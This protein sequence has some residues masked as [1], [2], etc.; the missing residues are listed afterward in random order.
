MG[1]ASAFAQPQKLIN[2]ANS[3]AHEANAILKAW[4]LDD[5]NIRGIKE[6]D[7]LTGETVASLQFKT[8]IPDEAERKIND[9]LLNTKDAFDRT[10]NAACGLIGAT[11][12]KR[13]YPWCDNPDALKWKLTDKK[14]GKEI[15]PSAFWDLI[16]S[17]QPYPR[18]DGYEGG[19]TVERTM[20]CFA[21]RKHTV[22]FEVVAKPAV[23]SSEALSIGPGTSSFMVPTSNYARSIWKPDKRQVEVFRWRGADPGVSKNCRFSYYVGFDP[24]APAELHGAP[25]IDL[26]LHFAKHAQSCLDGFKARCAELGF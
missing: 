2:W 14:T 1:D 25:A 15:I 24:T 18:G 20:A 19:L 7:P 9:A 4:F 16:G 26:I 5:N 10:I 22:G 3:G 17:Q 12:R 13:Y 6:I 8:A 11:R 23:I 21:N